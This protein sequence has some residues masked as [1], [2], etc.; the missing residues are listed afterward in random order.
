MGNV[1]FI[2]RAQTVIG[3]RSGFSVC[4]KEKINALYKCT[5]KLTRDPSCIDTAASSGMIHG[6][7][8][9]G[10][11]FEIFEIFTVSTTTKASTTTNPSV[12]SGTGSYTG[13]VVL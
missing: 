7:T 9:C 13:T 6:V 11:I 10:K 8:D 4:D 3:Q 5:S 1:I 2:N 12:C